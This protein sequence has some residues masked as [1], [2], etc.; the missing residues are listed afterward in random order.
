MKL[1]DFKPLT[2]EELLTINGGVLGDIT[3]P[4]LDE[5]GSKIT[6]P[7]DGEKSPN[8]CLIAR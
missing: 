2:K 5:D 8:Y 4:D 7:G 3:D 6:D 1:I